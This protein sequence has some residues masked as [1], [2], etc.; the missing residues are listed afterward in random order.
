MPREPHDKVS[1]GQIRSELTDEQE[2]R[3][4]HPEPLTE[5]QSQDMRERI[6]LLEKRAKS[7]SQI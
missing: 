4:V 1:Q 7:R 5:K 2:K 3:L 6:E